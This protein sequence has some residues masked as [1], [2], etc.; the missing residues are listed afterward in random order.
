MR[1]LF[2]NALMSL[3]EAL[4]TAAT[5][6]ILFRVVISELGIVAMGAW[7]LVAAT[8]SF[9]QI[10][11]IGL[12]GALLR[13]VP[14]ALS[15]GRNDAARAYVETAL[16][17]I[18]PLYLLIALAGEPLFAFV[19]T[20]SIS[21]SGLSL[22]LQILPYSLFAFWLSN[23]AIVFLSALA[24]VQRYDLRSAI[25]IAGM[26]LQFVTALLLIPSYGLLGLVL[27]QI[28]QN[29][30]LL[31]CG[32]LFLRAQLSGVRFLPVHFSKRHFRD[33]LGY[34]TKIQ[35]TGITLFLFEPTTK[36][37][38]SNVGGLAWVAYYEMGTRLA[39]QARQLIVSAGQVTVPALAHAR[40]QDAAGAFDF[41]IQMYKLHWLLA[42][43]VMGTLAALT[44]AIADLLFRQTANDFVPVALPIIASWTV[45]LLS[46]PSYFAALS[47]G[48]LRWNLT[49]MFVLA[50]INLLFGIVLGHFIGPWGAIAA[51]TGGLAIGSIVILFGNH[52]EMGG[53]LSQI[54]D[55]PSAA[56]FLTT[57][58][59]VAL[60]IGGYESLKA[61]LGA[62]LAVVAVL[63]AMSVL[64][65]IPLLVHPLSAKAIAA[66][67]TRLSPA[68]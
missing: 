59:G 9:S 51:S 4:C 48:K 12:G 62:I 16:A 35:L 50:G 1:P 10:A 13:F 3:L 5:A 41:Y 28:L 19:L 33:M 22:A 54:L 37:I 43:P 40:E 55:W 66:L 57:G 27:A 49:G 65:G 25:S 17:V 64:S 18:V 26:L 34:G 60:S 39:R 20:T 38:L 47:S 15:Q 2:R 11:D 63:A 29:C 58:V 61:S 42:W 68:E 44:P 67:R 31:I 53:S 21:G 8:L 56:V 23:V 32:C 45:S 14:V 7:A 24:G 46:A 52:L 30:L 6:F 36:L